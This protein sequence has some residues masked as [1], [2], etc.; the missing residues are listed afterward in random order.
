M[1]QTKTSGG[2]N[3]ATN[4]CARARHETTPGPETG[5]PLHRAAT[6]NHPGFRPAPV[7]RS[8]L[9]N[10]LDGQPSPE[11][12]ADMATRILTEADRLTEK[13]NA[14]PNYFLHNIIGG[15]ES[16]A[17]DDIGLGLIAAYRFYKGAEAFLAA[18][19]VP[20]MP[21]PAFFSPCEIEND[22][23][24][25][26]RA[27]VLITGEPKPQRAV[28]KLEQFETALM[29]EAEHGGQNVGAFPDPSEGWRPR[30]I[31]FAM[32]AYEKFQKKPIDL[33][34]R[35][36][37]PHPGHSPNPKRQKRKGRGPRLPKLSQK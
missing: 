13:S 8:V 24:P 4:T 1:K 26:E 6:T 18:R 28:V 5:S 34:K 19:R 10:A 32:E 31:L 30:A 36:Y 16:E 23:V 15:T 20:A 14:M 2:Q 22:C 7:V 35:Q 21:V 17:A 3:F 33:T 27:C 11:W 9:D 12:L 29:L 25:Y 37:A